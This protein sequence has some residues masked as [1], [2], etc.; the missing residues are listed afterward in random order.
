[1]TRG[2]TAGTMIGRRM[3]ASK[4]FM[5]AAPVSER[6][7]P[8]RIAVVGPTLTAPMLPDQS[9]RGVDHLSV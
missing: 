9:F 4:R 8:G 3:I 1:M 2:K 5:N 7:S 6:G